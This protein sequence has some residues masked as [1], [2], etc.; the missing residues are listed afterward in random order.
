MVELEA[1]LTSMVQMH[2]S[3]KVQAKELTEKA[4]KDALAAAAVVANL[5]VETLNGDVHKSFQSEKQIASEA[6]ALGTTVQKFNKQTKLW[7]SMVNEFNEALKEIGD[8]EN[9]IKIIEY[10]CEAI[11]NAIRHVSLISGRSSFT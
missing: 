4:K 3:R 10:D 2:A 6:Q 7:I 9:W 5:L 8:F 1:A 11:A